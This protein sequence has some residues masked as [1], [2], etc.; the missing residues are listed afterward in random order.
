MI[1][2]N[3]GKPMNAST[4]YLRDYTPPAYLVDTID[5][6]IA[7]LEGFARVAARCAMRRN[8]TGQ[9]GALVLHG[10]ELAIEAYIPRGS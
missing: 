8:P 9:G 1:E 5:L 6:D 3:R 10:E 7:I 2:S 4:I